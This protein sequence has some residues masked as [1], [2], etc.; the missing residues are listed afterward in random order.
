MFALSFTDAPLVGEGQ[1]VGFDN[2]VRLFHQK[3]FY[4]SVWN[5]G[6]FVVLTVLPNTLIGLGLARLLTGISFW[7]ASTSTLWGPGVAV[8]L[9]N[10]IEGF[11]TFACRPLVN[12]HDVVVRESHRGRPE[13]SR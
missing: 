7:V 12:V 3:L 4:T 11:S 9:V 8:G 6:Y 13:R 10:C 5:T 2:Y 1:W